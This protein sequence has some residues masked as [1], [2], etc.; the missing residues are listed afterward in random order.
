MPLSIKISRLSNLLFFASKTDPGNLVSSHLA[1]YLLDENSDISFFAKSDNRIW[2]RIEALAGKAETKEIRKSVILLNREYSFHWDRAYG[3]LSSWKRYFQDNQ[4]LLQRAVLGLKKMIGVKDF[5]ISKIPVYLVIDLTSKDKDINAWFS[6]TKTDSFIVVE[7]PFSL[8]VPNG[9]FPLAVL[10]HEFFH[11][12]LRK[13]EKL[14]SKIAQVVK[15]NERMFSKL[16]KG[17]PGKMFFEELLVSSFMPEGYLSERHFGA[18]V[19]S[20]VKR[21]SD[22]LGWRKFVAFKLYQEV[23]Q[24]STGNQQIDEKYLRKLA[25]IIK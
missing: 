2:Q 24:Y 5:V 17:M 21:P 7:I 22:I 1:K 25:G 3:H 4:S 13:N 12:L 16:A 11:L 14:F 8:K 15:E 19:V 9:Y 23:K 10:A 6:W 18:K 20:R